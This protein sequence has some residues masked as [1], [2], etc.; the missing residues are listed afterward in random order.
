VAAWLVP[1]EFMD[2]NYGVHVKRFLLDNV[3]LLRI[4]RFDPSDMQFDD[5]LVSSAVVFFKNE[6]PKSHHQVEFTFGGPIDK[7]KK[8]AVFAADI[9]KTAPKWT[10]MLHRTSYRATNGDKCTLADL[11]VI[12]RGLATGCNTFF[13]LT[14][15]KAR[16]I[17]IPNKFLRPILPSPRELE[18]D[19]IEAGA[20]GVPL[21]KSRRLLI[22]CSLSE[23]ELRMESP[24]LWSYL[25][26]GKKA[27]VDQGYLC[28]HRDPW[29]SQE[30]RP[31]PPFLCTYMGRPTQRSMTPFRFILNNS[32]AT[33]S[34][35]YLLLY[36]KPML[37]MLLA[38][39]PGLLREIWRRLTQI[40][41]EAL[42]GE[43][44]I[45]GGGLHKMEPKELANVSAETLFE[46]LPNN[47]RKPIQAS[48]FD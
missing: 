38:N 44:R 48:L 9:L 39:S 14:P 31:A 24:K 10:G 18:V 4:H 19:E 32:K 2:V 37:S 40:T 27:G 26:S 23:A 1:S 6:R 21:I 3:T 17:G 22:D 42:V 20:D 13:V 35:V 43:G 30:K 7:P 41:G 36:P 5:A 34:N 46:I 25:E 45:Y 15:E 33:A 29:Y 47:L 12:K 11:F 28:S 8:T 16:D